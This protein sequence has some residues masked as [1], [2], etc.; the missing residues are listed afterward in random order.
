[1]YRSADQVSDEEGPVLSR[2]YETIFDR[3][4]EEVASAATDLDVPLAPFWPIRGASYDGSLLVIGRS[5]NGW[6]MP[7]TARQ[8]REPSIRRSA[9]DWMRSN[10]E[11]VDGC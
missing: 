9:V 11:R 5:V 4:L 8:L 6:V 10:A 2:S 3:T 1:M 7:W